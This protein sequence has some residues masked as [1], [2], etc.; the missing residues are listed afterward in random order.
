MGTPTGPEGC[1]PEGSS[2]S[3]EAASHQDTAGCWVDVRRIVH[4]AT[5]WRLLVRAALTQQ[6]P[7]C[8]PAGSGTCQSD[9]SSLFKET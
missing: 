4:P 3:W 2:T 7:T 1:S 8:L 6:L 9:L 5:T